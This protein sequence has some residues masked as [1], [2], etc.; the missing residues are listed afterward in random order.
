M[1][2]EGG[3]PAR[4]FEKL[5][6]VLL[7]TIYFGPQWKFF[8][9]TASS[10]NAR[11]KKQQ[12]SSAKLSPKKKK[13]IFKLKK[14]LFKKRITKLPWFSILI[15]AVCLDQRWGVSRRLALQEVLR[16]FVLKTAARPCSSVTL[17]L[18][19]ANG[20]VTTTSSR[21]LLL[22]DPLAQ[23]PAGGVRVG[24]EDDQATLGVVHVSGVLAAAVPTLRQWI[25][26]YP[27]CA[28]P[29]LQG[30]GMCR[31][32]QHLIFNLTQTF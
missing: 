29:C 17:W 1:Q 19:G 32:S 30:V 24:R 21:R 18:P 22:C 6:R 8:F 23:L 28:E 7:T 4:V 5:W 25:P 27:R 26:G 2:L 16:L 14:K 3:L 15:Q 11:A 10:R 20:F 13:K 31:K 9:R 12:H